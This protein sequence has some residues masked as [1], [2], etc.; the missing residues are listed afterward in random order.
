MRQFLSYSLICLLVS[1]RVYAFAGSIKGK[2][3]DIKGEI[4]PFA[5]VFIQGTTNGTTANAEGIYLL[6]LPAGMH[7][8]TCQYMGFKPV[9][10]NVTIKGNEAI[11]HDF[12][13]EEQSLEMKG[14]VVKANAEDPAYEMIRKA[15]ARRKLHLDQVRSFQADIYLKGLLGTRSTPSKVLGQK[16][17]KDELGVDS[18]GKGILYL[19]EE[20]ASY[21]AAGG[22]E[23]TIVKAVH[24]SGNPNGLGLSKMPPIVTF[25]ENNVNVFDDLS[26]RGFISPVSDNALYYYKYKYLGEFKDGVYTVNKIKVI[27]RRDYEPLFEGDIYIVEGDWAIHS[28][29]LFVTQKSSLEVLDT[30]R[31]EQVHLPL[32]K[33]TWVIKNQVIY[34]AIKIFGFD[35]NGYFVTVYNKQKV[36][37]HLPDS[38]F[39][40]KV[41]SV[42]E[43][44]ANKKDTSYFSNSRPIPLNTEE[45]K[46]YVTKDS[47][48]QKFEDP[49]YLDSMRRKGNKPK[50]MDLITGGYSYA[51]KERKHTFGTNSLLDELVNFNTVEG[52]N[53][54]PKLYWW[55]KIDTVNTL[56]A[57]VATRYGFNNQHF[58]AMVRLSY[59]HSNRS[60]RGKAWRIGAEGG[61]YV[62]QPN[63]ISTVS[64]FLNTYNTLVEGKNY[65]KLYERWNVAISAGRNFGNGISIGGKIDYQTR[66]P[67]FNTTNYTWSKTAVFTDNLPVLQTPYTFKQHDAAIV[68]LGVAYKLGFTYTQY[69]DYKVANGSNWPLFRLQYEKAIPGIINSVT[70]YDKW[71]F[72]IEDDMS[73]KL[74]GSVSYKVA[75]GGFLSKKNVALPDMM[76]LADNQLTLAAPYLS[77]FQLAAYYKYSNVDDLY[78]EA[79]I[80]Y[81][82]KGLL[83]NKIPLLRQARWYL[84]LG[85]NTYYAGKNNYITEAFAG[86]DNLG[87]KAFRFLR[88]DFVHGWNHLNQTFY[89]LRIG[90]NGSGIIRVNLRDNEEW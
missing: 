12:K 15:I 29:N 23:H 42:Y 51:T 10:Y 22:K 16:I 40:D 25:Y 45:S 79:H 70:D 46:D 20:E 54:V 82:L 1:L 34:P 61:K 72:S 69:P 57:K 68:K 47:L 26:P 90:I 13:L 56:N 38:L 84:V 17:E 30:L 77:S 55:H 6:S 81:S 65:M 21:Y 74:F 63:G 62:F 59:S 11:S 4:L 83:T 43:A 32:K 5:T 31:I 24:E 66:L 9:V 28:A 67:L 2:I 73:L 86:I 8:V 36:N 52:I 7:K 80:E 3:T 37:E 48:R 87:Y 71:K 50:W 18:T 14:F 75:A 58:N 35:I 27:P 85:T 41:T 88:V 89:G 19:C 78:G 49:V 39:D 44:D 60:W 76:H 33:D 64:P 53:V